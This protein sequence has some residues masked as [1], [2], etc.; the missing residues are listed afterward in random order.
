MRTLAAVFTREIFARRLVFPV[1]LAAGF[2]PLVGSLLYG[3]STPD[4]AQ[5]R[6]LVGFVA[7]TA[8]SAAFAL[9]LGASMIVGETSEKRISFFFARPI[10]SA[11][12]WGGKLLAAVFIALASALITFTPAWLTGP[13]GTRG[14]WGF[15]P[16]LGETLLGALALAV[17]LVLGSHAVVTIGRLRSPWVALD[18]ILAP[19][20]LVLAA[21]FLRSLVRNSWADDSDAGVNPVT[22]ALIVL[23]AA[24]FLALVGATF[25]QV[26]EGRTDA[27]RAHGAFS[28][29]LFGIFGTAVAL[30]GGYAWWCAAAKAT[31]LQGVVGGVQT[32]ARGPWVAAGGPLGAW[33]GSGTFLFD[34]ASGRSLRVRGYDTVFSQDG[35]HAVWGEPRFG[36]FERRDNR[37]EIFVADLVKGRSVAT[38]LETAGWSDPTLSPDGRRL[39]ARD[40][41]TISAFDVS[42]PSNPRQLA[43]FQ[44]ESERRRYAFIDADTLRVFPRTTNGQKST[45][46]ELEVTELSLPS[47]KSLVTGRFSPEALPYLRLSPDARFFVGTRRLTDDAYGKQVL[48]LHDGRTG[49][50][51]ATLAD[52]LRSPQVRFLTGGRIAVAGIAG[53]RA[54]LL[55]F[56]GEKAPPRALDLGSAKRVVLGGEIAPGKVA[57]SLLPFEENLPASARAAKLTIVDVATGAVSPGPD[58]LV[59]ADRYGWWF[60]TVLPPAEAG[61]PA[62]LLFL[63][64]ESRLVRLDPAT[65]AKTVL[66]G[67]GK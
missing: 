30:V 24:F 46:H 39:A 43:V 28:V 53:A 23:A 29:V 66:L 22:A 13:G 35:T 44:V 42:D 9:L 18:L 20:L 64:A 4:A 21:V 47:K 19:A 31:D 65:G 12:I 33:R 3:W 59:P 41:K 57:V 6:V 56:E 52:D 50:L 16:G 49:A 2:V 7:A 25:V 26:A 36:F 45:G 63:D 34:P 1:A 40:G 11:A 32:A 61:S 14:L 5:G 38:G 58:G 67:K 8:L 27:R 17:F 55:V 54:G 15:N 10:P 62:S 60:N 37:S 51:V 48:T